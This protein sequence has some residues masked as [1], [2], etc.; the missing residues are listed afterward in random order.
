MEWDHLTTA[1]CQKRTLPHHRAF[2]D[3][4]DEAWNKITYLEIRR[5]TKKDIRGGADLILKHHWFKNLPKFIYRIRATVR[6]DLS[7]NAAFRTFS[8]CMWWECLRARLH[9]SLDLLV[10]TVKPSLLKE[11][12]PFSPWMPLYVYMC[13]PSFSFDAADPLYL[14]SIL[15]TVFKGVSE[16]KT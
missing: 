8:F 4:I 10:S 14:H 13:M 9:F 7:K 3:I 2:C 1:V 5:H 16:A 15:Y 12:I 6:C 11:F